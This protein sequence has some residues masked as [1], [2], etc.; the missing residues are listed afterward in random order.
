MTCVLGKC[1]RA[2]RALFEI[3]LVDVMECQKTRDGGGRER[4]GDICCIVNEP[5][6]AS[7]LPIRAV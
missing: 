3:N 2:L 7:N 4:D 5:V 6:H 1:T